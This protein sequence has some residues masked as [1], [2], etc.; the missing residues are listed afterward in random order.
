MND[1]TDAINIIAKAYEQMKEEGVDSYRGGKPNLTELSRRTGISRRII[2]R[3][4][5]NGLQP[6]KHGNSGRRW[7]HV[8]VDSA[9]DKAE[10][11]LRSGIV[12]TSVIYE[13]IKEVG[14]NGSLTTV[15]NFVKDNSDLVPAKRVLVVQPQGKI[16]RYETG[17]GEMFQMDWGFVKVADWAGDTYRC[18]CFAMVCHHCGMRYVEFFPNAK[19]ENLFIG[20]IHA[21]MFMGMPEIVLTDNMASVTTGRDAYGDVIYNHDYD[22]F[23]HALGF[24]TKL[25]KPRH[26]WTKGAVERLVEFVKGNFIQGRAFVNVTDLNRQALQWCV[27]ENA[28]L[29]TGLGVVPD[30]EHSKEPL[31]ELPEMNMLLPFLAPERSISMDGFVFY[32]GRRY[33]VPFSFIGKKARVMRNR[34]EIYILDP[35]TFKAIEKHEVDWSRKPHYSATQFEPHQPEEFPT[36]PVTA[37]IAFSNNN[38]AQND[39]KSYDF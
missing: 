16:R 28:K 10:E 6:H 35:K 25:C 11:L 32:E 18:A 27:K 26:P 19:Q 38:D 7:S 8:M 9:K 15:K 39:F 1:E 29:Q 2:G 23:Q 4:M 24:K 13:R 17:P 36:A 20:M 12:N 5:K 14:Y 37:E 34:E 21:F 31:M 22:A 30:I 33:G 3:I